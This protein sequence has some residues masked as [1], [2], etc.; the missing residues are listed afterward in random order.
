MNLEP[1]IA[2]IAATAMRRAREDMMTSEP[3]FDE[4]YFDERLQC[5]VRW[6]A[7][8]FDTRCCEMYLGEQSCTDMGGAIAVA[9]AIDPRVQEIFT[10][11]QNGGKSRADTTYR[12]VGDQWEFDLPK[13][14]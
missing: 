2:F 4:P 3:F 13:H 14:R 11:Q 5:H 7:Y 8:H 1:I 6:I 10:F 12:L 9:K